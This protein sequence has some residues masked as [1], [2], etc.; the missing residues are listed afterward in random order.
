[1]DGL[2]INRPIALCVQYTPS[3]IWKDFP[4][5]FD[6]IVFFS[7]PLLISKEPKESF[8]V[9]LSLFFQKGLLMVKESC[10]FTVSY[11]STGCSKIRIYYS[12]NHKAEEKQPLPSSNHIHFGWS[13]DCGKDII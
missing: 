4:L 9:L 3:F 13:S 8:D 6:L 12:S 1:M 2:M 11:D 7:I 5:P 10:L